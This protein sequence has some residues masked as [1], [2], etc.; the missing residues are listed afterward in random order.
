MRARTNKRLF[1]PPV[2]TLIALLV[3]AGISLLIRVKLPYDQVFVNGSVWFH[4]VDAWYHM[5]HIENLVHNFPHVNFFDPYVLYPSGGEGLARPFFDWLVAGIAWLVGLGSPSQ[6]TVDVVG[7][8]LPPVLG[9]LTIIPVYFI[10]KEL[11]NRWVG[12]LAAALLAI[13]PGEFLNR[14]LLG[15]T[16][17]HVAEALFSTVTLMF[18]IM[19][20]KRARERQI[21]FTHLLNRNWTTIRKPLIYALLAGVFLGIYLLSW[22]GGLLLIFVIFAYLVIQF[23]IDH[24]RRRSTDYLCII[25]TL[26]FLIAFIMLLPVLGEGGLG[27]IY[28]ISLSIAISTPIVLSGISH[29]MASKAI[30][31]AYYPI[32]LL[33]LGGISLAVFH[34]INPLLLHSMLGRFHM[35]APVAASLAILETHPL[36]FPFGH[37]S[38]ETAWLLFTTSFFISF[39]SLGFLVYASI[40]AESADKTLF[41]IWSI[42]MLVAVLGQRRFG[43]YFAVNAALLTAY[44]SWR[45][46]DFAGLRE[47][48]ARPKE[49]VR[50]AEKTKRKA[51]KKTRAKMVEKK[52]L[53]PS[54]TWVRVLVAGVAIFF[55]VFFP[56]V[57]KAEAVASGSVY[58]DQGWRSSLAWLRDNSPEPFGD[59]DFYYRLYETP[60]HYPATA[61]G[62]MCWWDYGYWITRIAHRIPNSNPSQANAAR[63]A[64]FFVAQDEN[65]AN[66]VMDEMGSRYVIIDYQMVTGKFHVI[67]VW[68]GSSQDEFYETYY[69]PIQG[70]KLE[71]VVLFYPAYYRSMVVRLYN[72]DGKAVVPT[73]S[74][75]ISYE[76]K[77]SSEGSRYKEITGSK[78]FPT[79]QDA[80]AYV[81][82]QEPGNWRIASPNPFATPVPLEELEYYELVYQSDAMAMVAGE[83]IPS[84]KIF[85]YVKSDSHQSMVNGQ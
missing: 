18:L 35:F 26:A 59:P 66:Q 45:T 63:V 33:S 17:H 83:R 8:Y 46:L 57:G 9:T 76:E 3:I 62:I 25:A 28:S 69:W 74:T 60:F 40:K 27:A 80:Q 37:F 51:K 72:F 81:S 31:V 77:V 22:I 56:N 36:L 70:G 71:P 41:L 16:D 85:E 68:A 34:A 82:S 10:G 50:I 1:S 55:L 54:V 7:A 11:F 38:L 48:L 39:V 44:F 42:L 58:I 23:I 52:L 6:H 61:Y 79:Y 73:E 32:A 19:A 49:D 53:Q 4:G 78:S 43:Y 84:V 75:V 5:R 12:V 67:P 14:S 30:K 29:L 15:F 65:S 21:S 47:L 64:D 20:I 2:I 13:L 24:L